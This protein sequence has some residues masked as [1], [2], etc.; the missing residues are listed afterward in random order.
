MVKAGTSFALE[1]MFSGKTHLALLRTARECG[2][3]VVLHYIPLASPSQAAERVSLRVVQGGH[4]VPEADIRRRFERSR[5]H[6]LTDYLPLAE[7]WVL[8]D[9]SSPPHQRVAGSK[10]HRTEES[11]VMLNPSTTQETAPYE[12]SEMERLGMEASRIATAKTI[13]HYRR[14]GIEVTPQMTLGDPRSEEDRSR[15]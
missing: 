6:R 15:S 7:E 12:L 8:W 2:Y 4:D 9:N 3:R 13:E 10:T 1:S 14:M 11:Q 5:R